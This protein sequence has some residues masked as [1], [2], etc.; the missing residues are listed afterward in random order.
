MRKIAVFLFVITF[1]AVAGVSAKSVNYVFTGKDI[2]ESCRH[3]VTG[4]DRSGEYDDH[5]FGVC[6]GYIAGIIDFHTVTTTVE[7]LPSDMF[8]LPRDATTAEVMRSVTRYLEERSDRHHD[9]A[10]YLV[11]LAL[12]EA[13][14]CQEPA[15]GNEDGKP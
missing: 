2:Y 6:A 5:R 4:L 8:C 15:S 1:F 9:L 10:A 7:S 12:Q 11:I 3:A 13:Y 14:P